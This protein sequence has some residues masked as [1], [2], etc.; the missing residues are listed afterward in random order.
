MGGLS[1]LRRVFGGPHPRAWRAM[2]V[3]LLLLSCLLLLSRS[4]LLLLQWW[5]GWFVVGVGMAITVIVV[6]WSRWFPSRRRLIHGTQLLIAA[7]T[8]LGYLGLGGIVAAYSLTRSWP[9]VV[10]SW[11]LPNDTHFE[12]MSQSDLLGDCVELRQRHRSGL[13]SQT[14]TVAPCR[15]GDYVKHVNRVDPNC[16]VTAHVDSGDSM[17][18]RLNESS[19]GFTPA[20]HAVER[21]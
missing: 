7:L 18:D 21:K 3:S 12:V 5:D 11:D 9:E 17:P 8:V 13:T 2:W 10:R 6:N 4:S 20:C 1:I 16:I 14:W 19:V 15:A